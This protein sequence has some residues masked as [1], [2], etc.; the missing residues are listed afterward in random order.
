[1]F[2]DA[3]TSSMTTV[4]NSSASLTL[5]YAA[6]VSDGVTAAEPSVR[7]STREKGLSRPPAPAANH[8]GFV[9]HAHVR[10]AAP[11]GLELVRCGM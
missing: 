9:H 5:G 11:E 2:Q 6:D 10:H 3:I 1:M 8:H 7:R 4:L